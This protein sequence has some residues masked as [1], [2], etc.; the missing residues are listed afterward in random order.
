MYNGILLSH[1]RVWNIAIYNNT[2]GPR[3]YYAE[4][5]KTK[6]NTVWFHLYVESKIQNKW[7][8]HN[9]ANSHRE[10]KEMVAGMEVVGGMSKIGEGDSEVQ[11]SSY[12][13][14]ESWGWY[15]QCGEYCL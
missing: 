1:R 6:T 14:N 2:D 15:V 10:N 7:K 12:N 5:N 8:K 4:W 11:P 3:G 13:I 9:K